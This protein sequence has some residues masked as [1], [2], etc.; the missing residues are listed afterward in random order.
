[1]PR[2]KI[3]KLMLSMLKKIMSHASSRGINVRINYWWIQL[4]FFFIF[5]SA[6]TSIVAQRWH[7]SLGSLFFEGKKKNAD[8]MF[9]VFKI[10]KK[11]VSL[12]KQVYFHLAFSYKILIKRIPK[13]YVYMKVFFWMTG[14]KKLWILHRLYTY[15]RMI[16]F[17][18]LYK[19]SI[20]ALNNTFILFYLLKI[21]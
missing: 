16:C 12:I 1:L 18:H 5:F 19:Q 15:L 2:F 11:L 8:C 17:L 6:W 4:S 7:N 13:G 14:S 10:I 3:V 20:Y 21:K 9:I